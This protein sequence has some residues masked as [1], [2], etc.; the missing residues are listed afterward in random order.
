[1]TKIAPPITIPVEQIGF[2]FDGVI[3][4]T[5]EAFIRL[6]CQEHGYC[7]FT[8]DHI[9][10]FELE[11][12]LDIPRTLV[13]KIFTDILTDS[14]ATELLPMPGAVQSLERF[15]QAGTLTII[16]ARPLKM[17]VFSWLER[18]FSGPARENIRVVATGDHND[19]VRHIHQ[20]G[21]KYFID[22]R[23]ETCI[24]LAREAITPFVFN[25]PWNMNRHDLQT[26]ADWQEI[27][28]LVVYPE[29][30]LP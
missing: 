21:L 29:Q 7:G 13:E 25:Q 10:N 6:A 22:D 1:M 23:A 8:C 18:Y 26:V 20:H 11:N 2:D 12:C 27:S 4:D 9:T 5:A 14:L 15:S 28:T 3:A 16:T 24:Q 30:E 19:K 17:P